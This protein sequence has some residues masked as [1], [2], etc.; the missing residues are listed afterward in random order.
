MYIIANLPAVQ[1]DLFLSRAVRNLEPESIATQEVAWEDMIIKFASDASVS[2]ASVEVA[3]DISLALF[4]R[5]LESLLDCSVKSEDE[6][7]WVLKYSARLS[8]YVKEPAEAIQLLCDKIASID[9]ETGEVVGVL[10]IKRR[11]VL[12]G[13]AKIRILPEEDSLQLICRHTSGQGLKSVW[14]SV[15]WRLNPQ[16]PETRKS[17]PLE[18]EMVKTETAEENRDGFTFAVIS[19]PC[20]LVEKSTESSYYCNA[21]TFLSQQGY[22]VASDK[23]I[24]MSLPLDLDL[25]L[26]SDFAHFYCEIAFGRVI[27]PGMPDCLKLQKGDNGAAVVRIRTTYQKDFRKEA[28]ALSDWLRLGWNI[29]EP[30]D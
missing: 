30:E 1:R 13:H 20:I 2:E 26:D 14:K 28:K 3:E 23:D 25:S 7:E 9:P 6:S 21:L 15:F 5:R 24:H 19:E 11:S 4:T 8:R 29:P 18:L 17:K 10:K 16:F 27:P 12:A 22:T